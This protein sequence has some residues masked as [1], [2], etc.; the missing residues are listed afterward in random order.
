MLDKKSK[1]YNENKVASII[2][3]GTTIRGE[4]HS[5][6]TIRVE[7]AII[8]HVECSDTIVVQESGKIK[9]DLVAGQ[10]IISGQVEGNVFAHDRLEITATGKVV[11]DITAP[12][13]SIAEGVL[14]EGRCTMKAP[15]EIKPPSRKAADSN[16]QEQTEMKVQQ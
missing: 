6:G 5:E 2:G 8:G 3:Q 4:I 10:V 7:G 12:R 9:A 11:G 16:G 14:F 1:N 15:G 13:I